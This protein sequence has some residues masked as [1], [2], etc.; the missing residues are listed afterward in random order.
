[1]SERPEPSA[2]IDE[3]RN[4]VSHPGGNRLLRRI[5]KTLL[6]G[7]L[8]LYFGVALVI[9]LLRY[10]LLPDISLLR[11]RIESELSAALHATVHIGKISARWSGLQPGVDIEHLTIV[12]AHGVQALSIPHANA[13]VAWISI[14]RLQLVFSRLVVDA[15]DV[16]IE[17]DA[18]GSLSIAGV[19]LAFTGRHDRAFP[20]WL[21]SQRAII[22]R[23]GTLRWRDAMRDAPELA[24]RD[25]RFA[26]LNDGRDHQIG[27]QAQPDGE[28]LHGPV[29]FRANFRS[30]AFGQVGDARA[31]N[32]TAY[33]TAGPLD[34]RTAAQ[35]MALPVT[36]GAGSV[37]GRVWLDFSNGLL[38]QARGALSGHALALQLTKDRPALSLPAAELHYDLAQD[39]DGA[40]LNIHNLLLEFGGEPPLFDG[41]PVLRRLDIERLSAAYQG[42]NI[43]RRGVRGASGTAMHGARAAHG[44]RFSIDGDTMD[45]GLL[46]D[47]ARTLP[48]PDAAADTLAR[49]EPRGILHDYAIAFARPAPSSLQGEQA[50]RNN[51]VQ[52]IERVRFKAAFEGLGFSAQTPKPGLTAHHHPRSGLPGFNNLRGSIDAD[53]GH[54][55][56]DLDAHAASVTIRGLF[57][58][59][60]LDFE[61]LAGR[62]TWSLAN[63]A[64]PNQP[65]INVK[66]ERLAFSNPDATGSLT[67]SYHKAAPGRG[68]LDLLASFDRLSVVRVPRYLPTSIDAKLRAYLAHA[69][70]AGTGHQATIEVR[71]NL[72]E[73]PYELPGQ[74]GLFKIVAPFKAARFDPSPWPAKRTSFGKLENWPPFEDINGR[75]LIENKLLRFDIDAAR[76]RSVQVDKVRGEITDLASRASPLVIGGTAR[77][78]LADM[79]H[80]LNESPVPDAVDRATGQIKATGDSHLALT[81]TVP[82]ERHHLPTSVKGRVTLAGNEVAYGSMVPPVSNLHGALDFTGHTVQMAGINGQWLG[83]GIHGSGGLNADGS[84]AIDLK[85]RVSVDHAR[86]LSTTPGT[87][88]LFDYLSGS[89]PYALQ[90]RAAR[91]A[92]PD[93]TLESDLTGLDSTLPAPFNKAA[94]VGMPL[95]ASVRRFTSGADDRAAPAGADLKTRLETRVSQLELHAGPFSANYLV[96]GGMQPMALRGAIGINKPAT[97]PTEGVVAA[98]DLDTLDIDAW[99]AVIDKLVHPMGAPAAEATPTGT[100]STHASPPAPLTPPSPSIAAASPA[101]PL[102]SQA[103]TDALSSRPP[104][105]PEAATASAALTLDTAS[106]TGAR[107]I[108]AAAT[109]TTTEPLPASP[110]LPRIDSRTVRPAGAVAGAVLGARGNPPPDV[111]RAATTASSFVPTR[112]AT[113]VNHLTLLKRHWENVVLGATHEQEVWQANLASDQISGHITWRAPDQ[114]NR[115]EIQA[116]LAKLEIP[117]A[118]EHDVVGQMLERQSTEFPAVDLEVENL[119]VYDHSLGRLKVNARNTEIDDEPVWLLDKLELDNPAAKLT[120]NGNWR[121]SRRA[122]FVSPGDDFDADDPQR[123]RRTVLEFKLDVLDA[124]AL[125]TNLGLPPTIENGKGT[126]S[127][128]VGWRSGPASINYPTLNGKISADLQDGTLVKVDPGV[129][130][131]LSLFSVHT[132]MRV[133]TLNFRDVVANGLAFDSITGTTTIH[134]GI[135]STDDFKLVTDPAR[136]TMSGTINLVDQQQ[137]LFVKIIPTLNFGT[138]A[139]A[140]AFV[141]PLIGLGGFVGQYLLSESISNT[142]SREYSVTGSWHKPTIRQIKSDEGKMNRPATEHSDSALEPATVTERPAAR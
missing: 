100:A 68:A 46:A 131:L 102:T 75:F 130:K 8:V 118:T 82:R 80:Y 76:Y 109:A 51:K 121:T 10:V 139:I 61:T 115:G 134:N 129:A 113:H 111:G 72:D 85:G 27:L 52:A 62:T 45:V 98:L 83:G 122:Y 29:D 39:D 30:G 7:A 43:G 124:G 95:R 20:N 81:I 107:T 70:L 40:T 88:A 105:P 73:F 63:T 86:S 35:Y 60:E 5:F 58:E 97:L 94:G 26:L 31:W 15:P 44:E 90:V 3:P 74:H 108:T 96:G 65:A 66:I 112:I 69:L 14:P 11:P 16:L 136:A 142:F 36:V 25:I 4:D 34:L 116:R 106:A 22:M 138:A 19:R 77:G 87:A 54:G 119:I 56:L 128:K 67:A 92:I 23:G 125:L 71:G 120:V 55:T 91:H 84:I 132:L 13:Q 12:D 133:L 57:D 21:L 33:A 17:R 123:P 64:D 126:L 59:P 9:L 47:I 48:L 103:A 24:L 6:V 42:P 117:R 38:T 104:A 18:S 32:G 127:G 99:R 79:I 140:V 28:V 110:A 37:A 1:M 78:P 50:Q 89:A 141:N 135:A 2:Y 114:G 49:F 53:E 41:T 93:L 137:A 101:D